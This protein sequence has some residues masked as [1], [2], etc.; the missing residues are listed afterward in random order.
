LEQAAQQL[1]SATTAV[2]RMLPPQIG[3]DE[4]LKVL[5]QMLEKA[6]PKEPPKFMKLY[7]KL[8]KPRLLMTPRIALK[9]RGTQAEA[10]R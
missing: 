5:G 3:A 7:M 9:K 2:Y 10:L 1:G 8:G 6:L 4:K